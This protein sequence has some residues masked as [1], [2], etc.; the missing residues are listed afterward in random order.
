MTKVWVFPDFWNQVKSDI[1]NLTVISDRRWWRKRGKMNLCIDF[2]I[3]KGWQDFG[4]LFIPFDFRKGKIWLFQLRAITS[5]QISLLNIRHRK[6]LYSWIVDCD[7][8]ESRLPWLDRVLLW[9]L[10]VGLMWVSWV[11]RYLDKPWFFFCVQYVQCSVGK[12]KDKIFFRRQRMD[13]LFAS[14]TKTS[15]SDEFCYQVKWSLKLI[16]A[17]S[18]FWI[19]KMVGDSGVA[20]YRESSLWASILHRRQGMENLPYTSGAPKV[21]FHSHYY[22]SLSWLELTWL[23][24]TWLEFWLEWPPGF[25]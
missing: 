2:V 18:D 16:C 1:Q 23:D 8:R 14:H 21:S 5:F 25:S 22:V 20:V 3:N 19:L 11:V 13:Q 10:E 7:W 6:G 12:D 17:I 9:L 4:S 15:S 24:L